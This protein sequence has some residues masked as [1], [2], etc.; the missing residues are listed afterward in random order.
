MANPHLTEGQAEPYAFDIKV[1]LQTGIGAQGRVVAVAQDRGQVRGP[2]H[3][4]TSRLDQ[5]GGGNKDFVLRYRL[6][7]DK[8]ETGL[9]LYGRPPAASPTPPRTSS[10]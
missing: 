4:P 9:L 1:H 2:V 7:G 6:A 5:T 3:A 10:P 8:I